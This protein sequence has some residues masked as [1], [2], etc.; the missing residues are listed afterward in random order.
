MLLATNYFLFPALLLVSF[1]STTTR[2]DSG[3][4]DPRLTG[5]QRGQ[6]SHELSESYGS[7]VVNP[8]PKLSSQIEGHQAQRGLVTRP[9]AHLMLMKG[10]ADTRTQVSGIFPQK[11]TLN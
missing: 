10:S 6:E 8:G 1:I 11:S 9:C 5:G 3:C 4:P 7:S 2:C